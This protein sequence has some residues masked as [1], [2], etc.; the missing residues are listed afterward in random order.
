MPEAIVALGEQKIEVG[1]LHFESDGRR[2]HS[3]FIY[4]PGWLRNAGAFAL[5][6]G[7][8]LGLVRSMPAGRLTRAMRC[9]ALLRM[10]HRIAGA[11]G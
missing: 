10:Q 8:P 6:P 3:T 4:S 1:R 7:L 5:A 9:R 11:A 2:Q